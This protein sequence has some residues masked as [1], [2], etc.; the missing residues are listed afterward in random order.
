MARRIKAQGVISIYHPIIMISAFAVAG[1]LIYAA[2]KSY[3]PASQAGTYIDYTGTMHFNNDPDTLV[4]ATFADMYRRVSTDPILTQTKWLQDTEAL[5][6]KAESLVAEET[7]TTIAPSVDLNNIL[8][9]LLSDSAGI[10]ESGQIVTLPKPGSSVNQPTNQLPSDSD[11]IT[12]NDTVDTSLPTTEQPIDNTTVDNTQPVEEPTS[13]TPEESTTT[14][15]TKPSSWWQ[16]TTNWVSSIPS[17]I[18]NWIKNGWAK[19]TGQKIAP[20][21]ELD[22]Y[23]IKKYSISKEIQI[24]I[25]G[26][27]FHPDKLK[28]DTTFAPE[29]GS[30]IVIEYTDGSQRTLTDQQ[31]YGTDT[32]MTGYTKDYTE[33]VKRVTFQSKERGKST[34]TK[35][36]TA[37]PLKMPELTGYRI[38]LRDGQPTQIDIVGKNFNPDKSLT[39][40]TFAPEAGSSIFIRYKDGSDS[41][42]N[43]QQFYGTDT[44]MTGYFDA[45]TKKID[46]ILFIT[47][48][49]G[50]GSTRNLLPASSGKTTSPIISDEPVITEY[51]ATRYELSKELQI[52]LTGV[53]FNP[54]KLKADTTFA[55]EPGSSIVV[56]YTDGKKDALADTQFFGTDT[57]LTGFPPTGYSR[58]I[59][60]ITFQSKDRGEASTTKG[61]SVGVKQ[62]SSRPILNGYSV[63]DYN[64]YHLL[65]LKGKSLLMPADAGTGNERVTII[66]QNW[67][68]KEYK[69]G[70]FYGSDTTVYIVGQPKEFDNI[71]IIYFETRSRGLTGTEVNLDKNAASISSLLSSFFSPSYAAVDETSQGVSVASAL[72][73]RLAYYKELKERVTD[74][75]AGL[76]GMDSNQ[77]V[78]LDEDTAGRAVECNAGPDSSSGQTR[79]T[80]SIGLNVGPTNTIASLK[81]KLTSAKN[82]LVFRQKDDLVLKILQAAKDANL[83]FDLGI[84]YDTSGTVYATVSPSAIN[85][86]ANDQSLLNKLSGIGKAGSTWMFETPA[87]IREAQKTAQPSSSGKASVPVPRT[88]N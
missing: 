22:S 8:G 9:Q 88:L 30:E 47:A 62:T 64:N 56:T 72:K 12:G 33:I 58:T 19:L 49:R 67:T 86:V 59:A 54:N 23:S 52:D 37:L 2:V 69:S 42:L 3:S 78:G 74:V 5:V 32:Q 77:F 79:C 34:T 6:Q 1:L 21:P 48:N 50:L 65:V 80:S 46:Y 20:A 70:T 41:S 51:K 81:S 31:F 13:T 35:N 4:L 44:E 68:S 27:N 10:L 71:Q 17:S 53:N 26:D 45:T 66:Y 29:T 24:D 87:W 40:T 25:F 15:P 7:G 76:E 43:D 18:G 60:K 82:N 39:D 84:H 38:T 28:T 61:A 14:V 36:L 83:P 16:K 63:Q 85:Q 75:L 73:E 57:S 11:E 55:P